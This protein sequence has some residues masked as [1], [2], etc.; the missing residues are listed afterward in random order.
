MRTKESQTR[1]QLEARISNEI[2]GFEKEFMGRG[3]LDARTYIISDMVIVR[4]AG[5]LTKAE[6]HLTRSER[7]EQGRDLLKQVRRELIENQRSALE[8]IIKTTLK[9]KVKTLHTDL[10]TTTGEKIIVFILDK[11]L[12]HT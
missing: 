7:N 4:L 11:P 6:R 5:V 9:R 1:G 2:T 3:P 8:S 12:E 10:S